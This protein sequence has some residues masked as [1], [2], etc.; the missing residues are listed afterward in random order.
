MPAVF[1]FCNRNESPGEGQS[2]YFNHV[3]A[4]MAGIVREKEI[5]N[6]PALYMC[7]AEYPIEER[8][9]RPEGRKLGSSRMPILT[10]AV[11]IL[12]AAIT[13]ALKCVLPFI[14]EDN[15]EIDFFLAQT[16]AAATRDHD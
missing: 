9:L 13:L 11:R 6:C 8:R 12:S 4:T 3:P 10:A 14:E 15:A 1:G 16:D 2:T 7:L 5:G